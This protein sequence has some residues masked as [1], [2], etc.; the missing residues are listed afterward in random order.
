LIDLR[1]A[2]LPYFMVQGAGGGKGKGNDRER[3]VAETVP[4]IINQFDKFLRRNGGGSG[5]FVGDGLTVADLIVFDLIYGA[6]RSFDRNALAKFPLLEAHRQKM[7]QLPGIQKYLETRPKVFLPPH[8]PYFS[9][10]TT[11]E[12]CVQD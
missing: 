5:Y 9:Y 11:E 4:G 7:N 10:G 12:E 1:E 8:L 6:L 2:I 3:W